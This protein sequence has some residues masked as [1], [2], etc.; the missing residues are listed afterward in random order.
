MP[1]IMITL[2]VSSPVFMAVNSNVPSILSTLLNVTSTFPDT[3]PA[4]VIKFSCNS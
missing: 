3:F 1:S 4:L 2:S